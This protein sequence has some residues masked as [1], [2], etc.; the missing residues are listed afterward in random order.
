MKRLAW[1]LCACFVALEG[2]T[3]WLVARGAGEPDEALGMMMIGYVVVGAVIASR[4]PR[5]AVGWILIGI[6]LSFA[7]QGLCEVYVADGSSGY[8][9]AAV[10]AGWVW[11]VWFMLVAVFLPL[12][13]PSGRLL[14]PL[15]RPVV[16]I[17]LAA[18]AAS[19]VGTLFTPGDLDVSVPVEN[20]IAAG[21]A[22]V[23]V[24]DVFTVAGDLLAVVAFVLTAASLVLRVRR[25]RGVERQQL[26]WFGLVGLVTLGAIVLAM[27][28]KIA[29]GGRFEAIGAVGWFTFLG[30]VVFGV[31][32][33]TGVAILRHRLYDIDLV[34]NRALVYGALTL[35]LGVDYLGTVLLLGL[36][37]GPLTEDSK[38]AVAG[39]TLAVAG[40]FGP[41]RAA[42]QAAVDRRF[43][44]RRYDA[45]RTL[46]AFGGRLR[47]E[48][49]LEA[50]GADV[51][52]VVRETVQPA[53]VS[54]WLRG[55]R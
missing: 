6:A 25:A 51:R 38:L 5:N 28:E 18:L 42:V 45:A 10:V 21:G 31:P 52:G 20:P 34:I 17:A 3:V 2:A 35:T 54:L 1:A 32:A 46:E 39:S 24:V 13:F 7:I 29:P 27:L 16:W 49:D 48:L 55:P 15:W 22:W 43:Y 4:H 50:L 44:R 40:L 23:G 53:H 30:A 12:L 26:K 33:A 47:D 36:A 37:L 8:L 11:Y 9:V 14:S 19:V 41:V